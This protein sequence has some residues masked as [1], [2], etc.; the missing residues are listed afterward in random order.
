M[1]CTVGLVVPVIVFCAL[2]LLCL[3]LAFAL[4]V[5]RNRR[6]KYAQITNQNK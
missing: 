2:L 1:G 5:R 6:Q 3:L 4:Y